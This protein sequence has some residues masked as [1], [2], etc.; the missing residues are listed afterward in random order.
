MDCSM[1]ARS[2]SPPP[3]PPP[4]P[5]AAAAAPPPPP[6]P[7]QRSD[8]LADCSASLS[9]RGPP[10]RSAQLGAQLGGRMLSAASSALGSV[11]RRFS[12]GPAPA[13]APPAAAP[14]AAAPRAAPAP[15]A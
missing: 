6:P 1:A 13:A 15:S 14:P 2:L 12:V 5:P 9:S 11:A 3:P 4:P 7:P 10:N 8:L